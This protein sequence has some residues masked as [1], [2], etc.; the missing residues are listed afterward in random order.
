M[1]AASK[2][3]PKLAEGDFHHRTSPP[4][5]SSPSAQARA[6]LFSCGDQAFEDERAL[7]FIYR[8]KRRNKPVTNLTTFGRRQGL[9]IRDFG[10][11]GNVITLGPICASHNADNILH[12]YSFR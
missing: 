11:S 1:D 2:H 6:D 7:L 4:G 3:P 9:H 12:A 8:Q 10:D 5:P